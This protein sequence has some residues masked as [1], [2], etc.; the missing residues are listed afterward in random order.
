MDGRTIAALLDI[1]FALGILNGCYVRAGLHNPLG[2]APAHH[3]VKRQR[4]A[5]AG[6]KQHRRRVEGH[7]DQTRQRRPVGLLVTSFPPCGGH[8][9]DTETGTWQAVAGPTEHPWVAAAASRDELLECVQMP[10][11][12]IDDRRWGGRCRDEPQLCMQMS[13]RVRCT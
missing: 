12:M 3:G 5:V 2:L 4:G 6:E 10:M 9:S 8:R 11:M 1:L 7:A 13:M